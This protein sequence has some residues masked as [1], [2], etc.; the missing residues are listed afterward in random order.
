[1]Q[2]FMKSLRVRLPGVSPAAIGGTLAT[3]LLATA[4]SFAAG[5]IAAR[6]LGVQG[7]ATFA[8]MISV[9]TVLS[10]VT[11]LGMD[12]A[13]A[14]FSGISHTAFRQIVRWSVVFSLVPGSALAGLWLLLGHF[15]PVVLLGVPF[16]LALVAAVMCPVTLLTTLLGTAEIGRGRVRTYNLASTVPAAFHVIGVCGLLAAGSLTPTSCFLSALAGQLLCAGVLLI[17]ATARVHDDGERVCARTFGSFAIKAYLPNLIHYGMLRLDVPVIQLLAGATAVAMYAV[18][19]P[20]AEAMFLLPTAVALVMFPAVTS[21]AVD[22]R[23]AARI[24]RTV[25]TAAA[26]AAAVAAA[27]APVLIPVIYGQ[28]YSGAVQVIWAMLP[29][30]VLF[31]TGRSLQAYLAAADLLR[32]VIMAT[33]AG[34]VVNIALLGLLT[35]HWAAVGAGVADSAGYLL[36]AVLLGRGMRLRVRPRPCETAEPV[37]EEAAAAPARPSAGRLSLKTLRH[38]RRGAYSRQVRFVPFSRASVVAAGLLTAAGVGYLAMAYSP[39]VSALSLMS[40]AGLVGMALACVLIPDAGLYVLAAAVPLSQTDVGTSLISPRRLVALML[41]CLLGRVVA[42]RGIVWPKLTGVLI[43]AGTVGYLVA[44]SALI[45]DAGPQ[46]SGNWQY[47]LLACAPMMLLP[48]STAP[49]PALDRALLVFCWG[50]VMVAVIAIVQAGAVFAMKGDLAPA[51]TAVL[52]ITQEGAANHNAVGALFVMAAAVMLRRCP[53]ARRGLPRLAT[54]AG[55]LVLALGIAYSLSRAAYLAGIVAIV[56]YAARRS[57]RGVLALGVGAACLVPLLPAAI[58]ARFDSILGGAP[59]ANS[60]VRLDLW[61]SALRMFEAHPLFGVGYL[62]FADQLPAYYQATG[63]YEIMFL[64]FPLLEFA[65]NTY[66]T[67]LSQTGL[68]GAV[69]IGAIVV[70][71]AQRAWRAI[72]CGDPAGEAALL[73]MVGAGVC[74]MFGE[75]LLVP[76]LLA[77]LVLI[78]LAAKPVRADVPP[79]VPAP[80]SARASAPVPAGVVR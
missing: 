63:D 16:R 44:A 4:M 14:R 19:L 34:A 62:N 8:V 51:D 60:A 53:V 49:G 77:G 48:L 69:G 27:A 38:R 42:G 54:G 10:I 28:P 58:A 37:T 2:S 80:A 75:V 73:A 79:P 32:P 31:S 35:P 46:S 78:I 71:G 18:A 9:P 43:T 47:L 17:A 56:L 72:R 24:A 76:P 70:L 26:V 3:R 5:V 39:A 74:S 6:N 66:L 15:S 50:S 33:G 61:S 68:V 13:N 67:V 11:V 30:L 64:Q 57:L 22:A 25:C 55:V 65:H 29:G 40:A 7:R 23:A 36:F 41:I 1:M 59:D 52:A 21:G 12:N 20:L 45:Y